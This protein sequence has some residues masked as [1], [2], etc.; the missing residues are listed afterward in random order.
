VGDWGDGRPAR[1]GARGSIA[2]V[3][4]CLPQLLSLEA[5]GL[6]VGAAC[7]SCVLPRRGPHVVSHE[8]ATDVGAGT[9]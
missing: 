9:W 7:N 1:A 5:K 8:G 3:G 2:M 4:R 6:L